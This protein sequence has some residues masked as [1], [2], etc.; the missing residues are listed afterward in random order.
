ML[1]KPCRLQYCNA[2]L[3]EGPKNPNRTS[4]TSSTSRQDPQKGVSEKKDLLNKITASVFAKT[5][6][7]NHVHL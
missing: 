2:W 6:Q 3:S 4:G 1:A 7:R 5:L